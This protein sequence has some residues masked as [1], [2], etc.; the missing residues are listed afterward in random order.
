MNKEPLL[1]ASF[2]AVFL[3]SSHQLNSQTS[4]NEQKHFQPLSYEQAGKKADSVLALMTK[5]GVFVGYRWYESKNLEPLYP[6]GHGLSYTAFEYGDLNV[7]KQKFN[8]NDVI[9]VSFAV[10]NIG[11]RKGLEIAQLYIQDVECSVPRPIKELKG[12]QKVDLEPGQSKIVQLQ[13]NKKAFSYWNPQTKD[14]FAE[15]GRFIIHVGSSSKD[16]RLKKELELI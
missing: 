15:K 12:F 5:E 11:G 8:E 14:W 6:F 3:I 2:C 4:K 10:K 13:L 16:L 7:S 1:L 9:T